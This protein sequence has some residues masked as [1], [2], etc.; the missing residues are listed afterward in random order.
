MKKFNKI[1]LITLIFI[2]LLLLF[3][4]PIGI[5]V[6]SFFINLDFKDEYD[7]SN[8][9]HTIRH[10]DDYAWLF[11]GTFGLSRLDNL[12]NNPQLSPRGQRIAKEIFDHISSGKHLEYLKMH[13]EAY[14]GLRDDLD[15]PN[16][17]IN[18]LKVYLYDHD[19]KRFKQTK[20][21]T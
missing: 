21:A 14:Q 2:T 5:N 10:L 3:W 11:G 13:K 8:D 19:L 16:W 17:P 7:I 9:F 4:R 20:N 12:K 6:I 18:V 15:C 1:A